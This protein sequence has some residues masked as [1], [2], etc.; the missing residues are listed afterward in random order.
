MQL[1]CVD[2]GHRMPAEM[3]YACAHCGGILEVVAPVGASIGSDA[4]LQDTMWREASRLS[5]GTTSAIVSLG[6]GRTPLH[7]AERLERAIP[8]FS[9]EI[10]L[11]DETVNPTGSFKDRLISAAVSRAR[12]LGFKGVVCASSG[13]AG[14]STSAYAARAGLEAIIVVPTHTPQEKL[15]QI[16]AYGA[17]LVKIDGHYSYSYDVAVR[18]AN[19]HG[20]VNLTT[21]FINPYGVDALKLAGDEIAEQLGGR[22]RVVSIN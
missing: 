19:E 9:G 15:T 1:S 2:C 6:E 21:T 10:W 11:K 12:E 13:N 4:F 5:V 18:L 8:R 17:L 16:A 3:L 22:H 20:L 14:A 7:R